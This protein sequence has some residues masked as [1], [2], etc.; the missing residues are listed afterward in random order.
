MGLTSQWKIFEN[1]NYFQEFHV[2]YR[3]DGNVDFDIEDAEYV[4]GQGPVQF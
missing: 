4:D 3:H 2:E 1:C